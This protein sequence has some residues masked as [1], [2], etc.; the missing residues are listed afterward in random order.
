MNVS[1]IMCWWH[2]H[3]QADELVINKTVNLLLFTP[4]YYCTTGNCSLL[5]C[6]QFH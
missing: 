4:S 2:A 5:C 1:V 6:K 3:Q